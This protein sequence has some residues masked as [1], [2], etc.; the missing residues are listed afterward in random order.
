MELQKEVHM[1]QVVRKPDSGEQDEEEIRLLSATWSKALEEKVVDRLKARSAP[2]VLLFDAK[3]NFQTKS[4]EACPELSETSLLHR[5]ARL[6]SKQRDLR[7]TIWTDTAFAHFLHDFDPIA[8]EHFASDTRLRVT[9][10]FRKIRGQWRVVHDHVSVPSEP[11]T[12][13]SPYIRHRISG[14]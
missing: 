11:D 6:R 3:Q 9:L 7:V 5:P 14:L 13:N 8:G 10:F 12:G 4:A 2:T 1:D